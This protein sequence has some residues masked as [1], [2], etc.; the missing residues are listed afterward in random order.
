MWKQTPKRLGGCL[1]ASTK[2]IYVKVRG[3]VLL[4]SYTLFLIFCVWPSRF[5]THY[6]YVPLA[7][8]YDILV[9]AVTPNISATATAAA[10][11]SCSYLDVLYNNPFEYTTTMR[12]ELLNAAE[13]RIGGE[14]QP[15]DCMP[16][17]STAIVVIYRQRERQLNEFLIYMHNFLRKQRIHYRIFIVEQYDQKP[18]NRAKLF[19]I[20]SVYAKRLGFP[21]LILHD[22]D[23]L[24]MNLGQLYV[25]TQQPRHMCSSLDSFR[26]T[27][28][29][30]ELF[31]GVVAVQTSHFELVNG[32]SNMFHGWGGEDDDL[33]RRLRSKEIGIC[34]FPPT[35][36]QYAMMLHRKE[37]PNQE[38]NMYLSTGPKRYL[39][40]GLNSLAY[41]EI[42]YRLHNL[43]T[44]IL[45]DT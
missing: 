16:K 4:I 35:H 34:R 21:C 41:K 28:P 11:G 1:F 5:A 38:R 27:L 25:C 32:M 8:L 17:F 20:G 40:D 26:F 29:Y 15:D 30:D 14:W 39:T 10:I 37:V 13:I 9:P 24:P 43:F 33:F 12:T 31:G 23:L 18:F 19:N 22:V 7:D 42:E 44:H 36:S 6:T 2:F 3:Y 45:V